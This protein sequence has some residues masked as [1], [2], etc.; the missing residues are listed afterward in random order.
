MTFA[1]HFA[2]ALPASLRD[3]ADQD[4]EG[5]SGRREHARG[6]VSDHIGGLNGR[7]VIA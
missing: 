7:S 3:A 5:V 2:A 1:A 6:V 4:V